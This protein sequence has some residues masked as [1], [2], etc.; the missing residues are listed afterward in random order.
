[1]KFQ[2]E[3]T[4]TDFVGRETKDCFHSPQNAAH[5]ILEDLTDQERFAIFHT[6]CVHCGSKARKNKDGFKLPCT[7]MRDEEH[8]K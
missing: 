3:I 1:M 4:R 5:A 7:C 8:A 2:V 6:Y